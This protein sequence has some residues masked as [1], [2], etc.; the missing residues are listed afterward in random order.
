LIHD[1]TAP[2]TGLDGDP[3]ESAHR[4]KRPS[5]HLESES[6]VV[7]PGAWDQTHVG[8]Q[9]ANSA[10]P[11]DG[12]EILGDHDGAHDP[13]ALGAAFAGLLVLGLAGLALWWLFWA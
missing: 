1:T 12:G 4:L 3:T 13:E 8:F 2:A 6:N 5:T 10:E 11:W 9:D 7:H